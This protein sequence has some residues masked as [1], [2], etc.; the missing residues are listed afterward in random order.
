MSAAP[1]ES[2]LPPLEDRLPRT[3]RPRMLSPG[4]DLHGRPDCA[5]DG[6][7]RWLDVLRRRPAVG[8]VD[9][10]FE[11]QRI[12]DSESVCVQEKHRVKARSS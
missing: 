12:M 2:M 3:S 6:Y 1:T 4:A 11:V 5:P 8:P 10:L 7:V 9:Q